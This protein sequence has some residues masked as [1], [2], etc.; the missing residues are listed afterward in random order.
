MRENRHDPDSRLIA[1][2]ITRVRA[3]AAHPGAPIFRLQGGPGITNMDF[4]DASRFAARH[5]VV[6]VGYRGIDGSSR[7]DCPEVVSAREHARD[8]LSKT[9]VRVGR[10]RRSAPARNGFMRTASISPA[11]RCP[12][13][14]T[15]SNSPGASSAIGRSTCVSESAGTRTA[16]IYA[17]RYPKSI[18]RSVMIAV[19]PPGHFVWGAQ[20][21][22]RADPPLRRALRRRRR[23]P[24]Q[25]ARPDRIDALRVRQRPGSLVVPADQAGQRA[26]GRVLRPDE[27]DDSG[28]GADSGAADARHVRLG[29]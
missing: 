17:W 7:L 19:N 6:L 8:L 28:G 2:P 4:P 18:H 16:M 13:A 14:S 29:R 20:D 1:L 23:L 22:R 27:R 26:G 25:D 24:E 9:Y 5:D 11:T 15:I 3:H 21:D 12:S 10:G